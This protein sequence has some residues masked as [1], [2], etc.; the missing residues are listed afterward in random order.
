M[1][2]PRDEEEIA[3]QRRYWRFHDLLVEEHEDDREELDERLTARYHKSNGVCWY[4]DSTH[5]QHY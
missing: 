1:L 3:R 2:M 5:P 4:N